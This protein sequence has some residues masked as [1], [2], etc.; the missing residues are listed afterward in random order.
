MEHE[1]ATT[2]DWS[3][4][5]TIANHL[6]DLDIDEWCF[7]PAI[8]LTLQQVKSETHPPSW[9]C[10]C[11]K[12]TFVSEETKESI[13]EKQADKR[14]RRKERLAKKQEQKL[15][16]A[17]APQSQRSQPVIAAAPKGNRK[18]A[19][20]P[21]KQKFRDLF[22]EAKCL[23]NNP[24]K[25][26]WEECLLNVQTAIDVMAPKRCQLSTLFSDYYLALKNGLKSVVANQENPVRHKVSCEGVP[27]ERLAEG[28]RLQ[29]LVELALD[30]LH[31]VIT[32]T[33][34][35][36]S[37]N[38]SAAGY[39]LPKMP[40][41][42]CPERSQEETFLKQVMTTFHFSKS[43]HYAKKY[44]SGGLYQHPTCETPP[45]YHVLRILALSPGPSI[46]LVDLYE[47]DEF[48]ESDD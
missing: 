47:F 9:A 45:A 19:P 3:G 35:L 20:M 27:F 12:N 29:E 18:I 7:P 8:K 5:N 2:T 32:A 25:A 28:K 10:G 37:D 4:R 15:V 48:D 22:D 33:A 40:D 46:F 14:L 42:L 16:A 43:R 26:G 30:Q 34:P 1:Q 17:S 44:D 23:L 36:I 31:F 41:E 39:E 21:K 13:R 11:C 6:V 24:T 38:S